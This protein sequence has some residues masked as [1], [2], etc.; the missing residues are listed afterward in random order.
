[1]HLDTTHANLFISLLYGGPRAPSPSFGGDDSVDGIEL[2]PELAIIAKTA[3]IEAR[4]QMSSTPAAGSRSSSPI[5]AI[6]PEEVIIKVRWLS[7]PLNPDPKRVTYEYKMRRVRMYAMCEGLCL[8]C[9]IQNDGFRELFD[10]TADSAGV[11]VDHIIISYEGKRVFPSASPHGI[12]VWDEAV[13]GMQFL[14][15]LTFMYQSKYYTYRRGM[16]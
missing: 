9:P 1:M 7:H 5:H 12:G 8:T 16:R 13:L 14:P 6:G 11:L 2:D 15:Y 10:E 3:Q 4:R